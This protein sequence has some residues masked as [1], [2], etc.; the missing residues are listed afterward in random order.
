M[1]QLSNT[2]FN[3]AF[4][5]SNSSW[6][7]VYLFGEITPKLP[8]ANE[9]NYYVIYPKEKYVRP[10]GNLSYIFT[11][12]HGIP[13]KIEGNKL[14]FS[15]STRIYTIPL[16]DLK[17]HTLLES[18]LD[19][20]EAVFLENG[21]LFYA[22]FY[23]GT[24]DYGY[25]YVVLFGGGAY[26]QDNVKIAKTNDLNPV[27]LFFYDGKELKT[28]PLYRITYNNSEFKPYILVN[29]TLDF[30]LWG[31]NNELGRSSISRKIFTLVPIESLGL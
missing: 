25:P 21:I 6:K 14:V 19:N 1:P 8:K 26:S 10:L 2:D 23:G 16:N 30:S 27:V 7:A 13:G 29:K 11:P 22:P 5:Y 18:D 15:N 4:N 3:V 31:T 9:T 24:K 20:L 17:N 12:H 28:F